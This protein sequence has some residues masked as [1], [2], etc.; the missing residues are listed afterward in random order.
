MRMLPWNP[1]SMATR[2]KNLASPSSA[3]TEPVGSPLPDSWMIPITVFDWPITDESGSKPSMVSVVLILSQTVWDT[4]SEL[5]L[6]A[7]PSSNVAV[8]VLSPTLD[9]VLL[10]LLSVCRTRSFI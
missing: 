9:E 4:V 10:Q 2:I 5:S 8:I 1:V 6:N 7:S 3:S